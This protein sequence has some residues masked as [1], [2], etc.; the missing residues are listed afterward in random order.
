MMDHWLPGEFCACSPS[1]RIFGTLCANSSRTHGAA[2]QRLSHWLWEFILLIATIAVII[3]AI[4]ACVA[5]ARHTSKIE[6]L[7]APRHE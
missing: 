2:L 1:P 4:I 6:L 7:M 3:V 5:P